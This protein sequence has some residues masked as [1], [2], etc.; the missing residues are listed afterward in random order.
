MVSL[1]HHC[2]AISEIAAVGY[3]NASPPQL[4][5]LMLVCQAEEQEENKDPAL[6]GGTY[7][8][9]SLVDWRQARRGGRRRTV[10]EM[11]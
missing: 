7:P 10:G 11:W 4:C 1:K 9:T 5:S 2:T 6:S 8:V 3:W